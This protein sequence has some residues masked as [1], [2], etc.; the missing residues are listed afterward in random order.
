[1]LLQLCQRIND[2]YGIEP[3]S[4][5]CYQTAYFKAERNFA[6]KC[7]WRCGCRSAMSM[8]P[9]CLSLAN[10]SNM[11]VG[12]FEPKR[13]RYAGR[14]QQWVLLPLN[15]PLTEPQMQCLRQLMNNEVFSKLFRRLLGKPSEIATLTVGEQGKQLS[16]TCSFHSASL[17]SLSCTCT[18]LPQQMSVYL[19][20]TSR[21]M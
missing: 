18:I 12:V 15:W 14:S 16:I 11:L 21:R 8:S 4:H 20:E 7:I 1:M 10:A 2:A 17:Q 3:R 13:S 19:L 5:F 9:W 6:T